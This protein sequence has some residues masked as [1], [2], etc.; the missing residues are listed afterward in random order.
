MSVCQLE[1]QLFVP[2]GWGF[3]A[4]GQSELEPVNLN[5]TTFLWKG[6]VGILVSIMEQQW[7]LHLVSRNVLQGEVQCS[8][9]GENHLPM[10]VM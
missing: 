9:V 7:Q 6:T 10:D 5:I 2:D 4:E 1:L 3:T 8:V